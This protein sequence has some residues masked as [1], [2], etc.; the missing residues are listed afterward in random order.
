MCI[1]DRSMGGMGTFSILSQRPD[2]FAA[3]T[4]ICGDGDPKSVKSFAKK[5]PIWIFHG[6]LDRDVHPNRSLIMAQ[7]I[8]EE[9]GSPRVTIYENVYHDSW[10]NAFEE[11]D[12]LSWIYSKSK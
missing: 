6:A 7:A 5:V 3:A 9:N 12:F 11:K 2:M 10:N 1:R 8:I 4:P